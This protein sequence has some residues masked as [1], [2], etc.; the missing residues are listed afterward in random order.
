[1]L[2]S[3]KIHKFYLNN[4]YIVLDINS[5]AVHLVDKIAYDVLDYYESKDLKEILSILSNEYSQ[6][7]I[8]E[9]YEEINKIKEEGL[10]FS[11]AIN[12]D[13]FT[14]NSQNVVKALCLHVA[15]DCNLRCKYCFAS[16]G[17][18]KGERLMMPLEV[19]KKALEFI[20]NSSGNRRNLEVDF[21][22]GEPLMN[23]ELVKELVSYGRKL[24]KIYN[25]RFRFTITTNGVLLDEDNMEFI[26]ENMDNVVLS[27]DGRKEVNDNMRKTIN[28]QGSYDT[29][30]PKIINMVRKRGDKDYFVRGTFTGNNLDFTQDILEFY[31]LGF[32]KVSIEPVV[33]DP[34]EEYA[35]KEEDL[36]KILKEYEKFSKE[37]IKIKKVD[38][39][40]TFFHFMINLNQ[41][42]CVIKRATGCGAGSEYMA[43]T[44]EGDLYPCHQF[45]GNEDFKLGDVYEG[46]KNSDIRQKFK[47]ANVFSKEECKNC[48]A[49]FYCSGGCHANAFNAN[50]DITKPY[51][52][53]CE[54]EKKRIECAISIL[55]NLE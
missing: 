18:F 49:R 40:F 36:D 13:N 52:I 7:E 35:I 3:K 19:G 22:G 44:P 8:E 20:V 32:K 1:M 10:L 14:Y 15:H 43:V 37:Y 33:T 46:V 41:G 17:D 11:E 27:L 53:G 42:P 55:A 31:N 29:I 48:W 50:K 34:K 6:K 45:V 2:Y 24:E 39:D 4:K 21:F 26:N 25:K 9:A 12:I 47:Q 16:Q 51:K 5:G 38:R 30:V 54:M 23:F 28:G